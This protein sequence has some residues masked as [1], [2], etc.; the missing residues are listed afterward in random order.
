MPPGNAELREVLSRL[1]P[2]A[3]RFL[4][5]LIRIHSTHGNEAEAVD[6]AEEAWSDA[7]FRVELHPIPESLRD[8]PEY[9]NPATECGFT[10]RDNLV[11]R[12][13]RGEDRSVIINSHL[14]VVPAYDWEDAFE[15]RVEGDT[16]YGRG[17]CD[18]KGCVAAMFLA[19]RALQELDTEPSGEI[20]FQ[21][22]VDEE[23]GGNGSL[24]IV[25]EGE[26]ADGVVVIEPTSLA[27]HPANRG[28]IW[29]RFEFTGKSC[30]MGR[31]HEGVNAIDL[32]CETMRILYDYEQE[33]IGD[34]K[35][36]PLFADYEFPTQVNVGTLHSGDWPSM[37]PG[38]AV[39]EGG[40]GFLPNRPMEQVKDDVVR[41]IEQQGS[42][43][44]KQR[45]ELSFPRLHNDSYE[46]PPDH[47]FVQAF[48]RAT[49]GTDA[50]DTVTGW[51]VSCD[52]R[53][54]AKVGGMPTVVFGPGD[55]QDAH[56]AGEKV[57]MAD[58]LTTAETLV[59]FIKDWCNDES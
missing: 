53:L 24:A 58:I 30:H 39:M 38:K 48:H 50:R 22:V 25:R 51:N 54:F 27:M 44:L 57:E 43:E 29:F 9:T 20:A 41:Y 46:T 13:G 36:Q 42:D 21:M 35:E 34:Q 8:D 14:D 4:T 12:I 15:P 18:A 26:R 2:E 3:R 5:G 56:S 37:V 45:Y 19:A 52:A 6:F 7:G 40:I 59:R 10:G 47:P 23:V 11:V 55:I 32:A 1:V 28:A 31:K 33:L 16:V 49:L 17:A